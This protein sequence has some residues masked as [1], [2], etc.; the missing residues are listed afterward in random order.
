MFLGSV[1]LLCSGIVSLFLC[2]SSGRLPFAPCNPRNSCYLCLSFIQI[3]GLVCSLV[4]ETPHLISSTSKT[5]TIYPYLV[6]L[7]IEC[8]GE[9]SHHVLT[10][11]LD[12]TVLFFFFPF[13]TK[14]PMSL[15]HMI[16]CYR[17]V[18]VSGKRKLYVYK[19]KI[20]IG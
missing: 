6:V 12:V 2:L 15:N 20:I 7:S 18:T 3:Q 4:Y 11:Y 13:F 19:P 10:L 14:V 5:R 16:F 9:L 1:Y 17:L 8:F